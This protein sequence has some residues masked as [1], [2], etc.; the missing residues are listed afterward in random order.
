MF[1]RN[2]FKLHST[3]LILEML[4]RPVAIGPPGPVDHS[5]HVKVDNICASLQYHCYIKPGKL[6]HMP[7]MPFPY[8]N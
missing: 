2:A 8:F 7:F 1:I 4:S 6:C 3:E 5:K